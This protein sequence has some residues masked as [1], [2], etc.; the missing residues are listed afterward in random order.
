MH[1]RAGD[2]LLFFIEGAP[3]QRFRGPHGSIII[4][5]VLS[6]GLA[7]RLVFR[8]IVLMQGFGGGLLW[9]VVPHF[10]KLHHGPGG[11]KAADQS[12]RHALPEYWV[13]FWGQ[14]SVH[15]A[16]VDS[17]RIVLIS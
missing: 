2:F 1:D 16:R 15:N 17:F 11:T 13:T 5:G 7:F 6:A 4:L 12:G 3:H 14:K 8:D 9:V 10:L